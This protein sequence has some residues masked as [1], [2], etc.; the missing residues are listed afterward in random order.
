VG[1]G[2]GGGGA[3]SVSLAGTGAAVELSSGAGAAA[4]LAPAPLSPDGPQADRGNRAANPRARMEARACNGWLMA[5]P[6]L[7]LTDRE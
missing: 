5:I 6:G 7:F 3:G 4:V 1:A 2:A